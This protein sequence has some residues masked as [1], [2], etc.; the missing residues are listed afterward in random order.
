MPKLKINGGIKGEGEDEIGDEIEGEMYHHPVSLPP[1]EMRPGS[2]R[3]GLFSESFAPVKNGVTAS[4]NT[5]IHGMRGAGHRVWVCAPAH[6]EQEM[7]ETNVLR[8]PSFVTAY[9]RDYPLAYPFYPRVALSTHFNRLRLDVVH[10]HTPFVLGLTG[11]KLAITRGTPLISTFHTLYSQY[12][13]YVPVLPEVMSQGLLDVYLPW[14]YNKCTHVICPSQMA[15]SVLEAVGVETPIEVIPTG[16]PLPAL[17]EIDNDARLDVR[18]SRGWSPDSPVLLYAGRLSREKNIE[19][20]F[21]VLRIVMCEAPRT[22][23]VIAGSG[24]DLEHLKLKASELGVD[25]AV[26]FIGAVPRDQMNGL[27]AAADVLCFP[28]ES[29]TQGL[30]IGEARAAGLPI[31]VVDSGGAPETVEDGEDGYRVRAGDAELFA[32]RVLSL[33]L[34]DGGRNRMRHAAL[35]RA[36]LFTPKCMIERIVGVYESARSKPPSVKS[37]VP[38]FDGKVPSWNIFSPR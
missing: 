27:Y 3:I 2:L 19:W 5:L 38:P 21:G 6:D 20:L 4:L 13:H 22:I 31:V 7:L 32:H 8:F 16:I 9:N 18:L 35:H 12:T 33:I 23:L 30:V 10:T 17:S 37:I 34:N 28:S 15:K 24:P 1:E 29:E 11:A 25:E 14:Y 26:Q 36:A